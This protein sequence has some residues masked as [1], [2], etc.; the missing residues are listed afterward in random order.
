MTLKD[1]L[2]FYNRKVL[3]HF[4]DKSN[5]ASIQRY[6]L[7][8]L[9]IIEKYDINVSCYGA[10]TLSHNLDR[11]KGL[12]RYVHLSFLNEHPMHYRKKMSGEIPNPIWLAIDIA[13]LF[14]NNTL[15]TTDIA[16]KTGVYPHTIDQ[17][18]QKADLEVLWGETDWKDE[19]IKERRKVAKKG[20]LLVPNIIEP[21]YILK[22][23]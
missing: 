4:T 14:Q 5:L 10:D 22:V 15:F 13:V 2:D 9:N 16:N 1:T 20:E 12:D 3:W 19:T 6:G 7:L 8:S 11:V 23:A 17:L 21:K 18:Q